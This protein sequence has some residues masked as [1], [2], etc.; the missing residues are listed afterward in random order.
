MQQRHPTTVARV[1]A[2]ASSVLLGFLYILDGGLDL[3]SLLSKNGTRGTTCAR[4][5][6]FRLSSL[7]RFLEHLCTPAL[8]QLH[9]F[10]K[11]NAW[12]P[13]ENQVNMIFVHTKFQYPQPNPRAIFGFGLPETLNHSSFHFAFC[14]YLMSIF[15]RKVHRYYLDPR[16]EL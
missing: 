13:L 9:Y 1:Q 11:G 4:P 5:K 3:Q 2:L 14:K 12:S 6:T 7:G 15:H 8:Q 10:G 16:L